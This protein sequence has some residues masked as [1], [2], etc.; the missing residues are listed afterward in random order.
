MAAQK[1]NSLII[2][3]CENLELSIAF[4][5]HA[6]RFPRKSEISLS[7]YDRVRDII[8]SGRTLSS[9]EVVTLFL[10]DEPELFESYLDR[11]EVDFD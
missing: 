9:K 3:F 8:S 7:S 1:I 11:H 4:L 10:R 5:K 6:D 2:L